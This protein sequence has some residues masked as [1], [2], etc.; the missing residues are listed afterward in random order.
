M[1]LKRRSS[2]N[3]EK[4]PLELKKVTS[5]VFWTPVFQGQ[6]G[7]QS[8]AQERDQAPQTVTVT[9]RGTGFSLRATVGTDEKEWRE[10]SMEKL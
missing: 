5:C 6:L 7:P 4:G 2:Q 8:R 1:C 10:Q 3:K 9:L